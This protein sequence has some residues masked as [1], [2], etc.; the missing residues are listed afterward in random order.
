M[1]NY[2][3]IITII[4]HYVKLCGKRPQISG[5]YLPQLGGSTPQL[6]GKQLFYIAVSLM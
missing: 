1:S 2:V 6:G 3:V 4:N 5:R